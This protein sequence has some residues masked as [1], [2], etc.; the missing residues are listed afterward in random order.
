MKYDQ[1]SVDRAFFGEFDFSISKVFSEAWQ[2]VNGAKLPF[3]GATFIY[4]IIA[5]VATTAVS[6]V[7]DSQKYY[8]AELYTQAFLSDQ[9]QSL[10]T[11]PIL[12]P[13]MMGIVMMGIKRATDHEFTVTN[14]FDY[15]VLVWPLV[16]AS[17]LMNLM[18]AVGLL[19]LILP[20]I[21]LA[22]AYAFTLPLMIDKKLGI[23]DAMELS[24]KAVS[25]RWFKCFTYD[26]VV[27]GIILLSIIPF[28]IGLIWSLPLVY[29][30]YGILY[31][32]VFGYS[33][34]EEEQPI[35]PQDRGTQ[36]FQI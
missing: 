36:N 4:I 17:L 24:R 26:L 19:L 6:L 8:D 21:Y 9:A 32:R 16:F 20:G 14:I 15:Y 18:I 11:L 7:F 5:V 28:G 22:V 29:I 12:V 34:G 3:V 1:G 25:H 35:L 33:G 27:F 13:L 23:W 31:R 30:S 10:L 2:R